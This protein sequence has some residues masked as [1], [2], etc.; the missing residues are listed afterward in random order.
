[1][2]WVEIHG[3]IEAHG[4]NELVGHQRTSVLQENL[5]MPSVFCGRGYLD[6]SD[7]AIKVVGSTIGKEIP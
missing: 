3:V 2:S 6:S 7:G 1:M 5:G 4:G